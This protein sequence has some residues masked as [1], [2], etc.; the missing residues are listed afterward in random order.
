MLLSFRTNARIFG[1]EIQKNIYDLAIK[2]IN[3]NGMDKQIN[4][5]NADVC[6]ICDDY[7]AESFDVVTFNPPYFKYKKDSLVNDNVSK[8]IARHEVKIDLNTLFKVSSYLVKNGGTIA[9]VHRTERF[10]EIMFLMKKYNIPTARYEVFDTPE[11]AADYLKTTTFP[12][13]IKADGLALGK[14]V[15]IPETLEEAEAGIK[16]IM[17]DKIFGASGNTKFQRC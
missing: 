8:T 15:L 7:V 12:T 2:S 4:I 13:V 9:F 3:E 6:D 16:E 1:V 14:G 17:E 11:A 10:A 5:L